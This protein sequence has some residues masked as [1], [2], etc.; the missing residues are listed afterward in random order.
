M[1]SSGYLEFNS[2]FF[3][4]FSFLSWSSTFLFLVTLQKIGALARNAV[5]IEAALGLNTEH[6]DRPADLGR[7]CTPAPLN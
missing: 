3:C 7:L 1:N 6:K 5:K 2:T 4:G